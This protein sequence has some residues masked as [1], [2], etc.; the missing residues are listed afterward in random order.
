MRPYLNQNSFQITTD[1]CFE[2]VMISC[3]ENKRKGQRTTWISD[4]MIKAYCQLHEN[5]YAHS[6]EVWKE[7]KLVGGLYGIALG[8]IF[9]GESMFTKVSNASKYGFIKLTEFLIEKEYKLIDCQQKTEHMMSLGAEMMDKEVFYKL[10]KA[11]M[12]CSDN[13]G[14]WNIEG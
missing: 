1:R 7:E 4:E 14:K 3:R 2:E 12:L 6:V 10:L 13:N 8:K 5:G 11:N 9:Y